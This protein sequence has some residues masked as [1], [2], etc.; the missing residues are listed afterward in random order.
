[1]DFAFE[2]RGILKRLEVAA[3]LRE[4]DVFV[5]LSDYQAFGRTGLEAMACGCATVLPACGGVDEYA[6]AGVNALL[7]D[8][9]SFEE[10]TA[11]VARLVGDRGLRERLAERALETAARY[12]VI[13]A[14]LSEL[15]VFRW[16]WTV[17][18]SRKL[19]G[20]FC[21]RGIEPTARP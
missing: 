17:P 9:A 16:A 1:M 5:D 19:R 6:V 20:G 13:R 8:T 11:A 12:S 4:A 21:R 3:L 2:N 15:S 10:T 7:V 18:E 14:S